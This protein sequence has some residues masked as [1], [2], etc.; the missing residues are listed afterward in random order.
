MVE[1]NPQFPLACLVKYALGTGMIL[2]IITSG[3]CQCVYNYTLMSAVCH[4]QRDK[5]NSRQGN[6]VSKILKQAAKVIMRNIYVELCFY[7][8]VPGTDSLAVI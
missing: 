7:H 8:F 3:I 2:Y 6:E 5:D 4:C 1:D